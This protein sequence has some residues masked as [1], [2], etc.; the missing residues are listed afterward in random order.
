MSDYGDDA[1]SVLRGLFG[2][3]TSAASDG[4]GAQNMWQALRSGAYNWASSVLN[5][6]LPQPPTEQDIIDAANGLIGH[7]TVTDMN[8]YA[9]LAG[10]QV[11]AQ[12]ILESLDPNEEITGNAIFQPPWA[13]T[14]NNPAVPTRYR[15]RILRDITVHGFTAIN[16][17][18]W[19]TYELGGTLTTVAS[20]LNKANLMF[21]Q[22]DYN[23]RADI[24]SVLNYSIEVV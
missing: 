23:A 13:T 12:S 22:A 16:R 17:Q 21:T 14:A 18:E 4:L 6:T 19:A 5:V 11:R 2:S 10:Q 20:A 3:L 1:D 8:R 24:N 15:I 9:Q 7:V